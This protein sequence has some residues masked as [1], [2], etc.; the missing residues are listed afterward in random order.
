MDFVVLGRVWVVLGS[1]HSIL[2]TEDDSYLSGHKSST[3]WPTAP[4]DNQLTPGS[5]GG[6]T[7]KS[8]RVNG[9]YRNPWAC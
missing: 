1:V 2:R 7:Y 6:T 4:T 3:M 8:I 5:R 9:D